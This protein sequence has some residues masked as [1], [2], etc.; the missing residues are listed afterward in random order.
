M[1]VVYPIFKHTHKQLRSLVNGWKQFENSSTDGTQ[2]QTTGLRQVKPQPN[3]KNEGG[4][5]HL[6]VLS[7]SVSKQKL[8]WW[9]IYH[10]EFR[11]H[12]TSIS[13]YRKSFSKASTE[14]T[15]QRQNLDI[16]GPFRDTSAPVIHQTEMHISGQWGIFPS[17]IKT[18]S[19]IGTSVPQS[20]LA[21]VD[22]TPCWWQKQPCWWAYP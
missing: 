19:F 10:L 17:L 16:L 9:N 22:G 13:T 4:M 2:Y 18:C 6:V 15:N 14:K 7:N 21:V 12:L 8:I 1:L 5:Q 20:L 11:V 3:G